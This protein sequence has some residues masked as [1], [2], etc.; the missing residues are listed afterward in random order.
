MDYKTKL[1]IV[2]CGW[3]FCPALLQYSICVVRI[4]PDLLG[5]ESTFGYESEGIARAEK[6]RLD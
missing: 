4:H 2:A 1:H 5:N 6:R 3:S